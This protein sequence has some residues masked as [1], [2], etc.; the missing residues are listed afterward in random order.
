MNK[1]KY[2]IIFSFTWFFLLLILSI[3]TIILV[4][5]SYLL[6]ILLS[7]PFIMIFITFLVDYLDKKL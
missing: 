1:S 4:K 7:Y 3:I 6:I 5:S 2:I